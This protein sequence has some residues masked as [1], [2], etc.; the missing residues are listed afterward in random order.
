[1]MVGKAQNPSGTDRRGGHPI[2]RRV[3]SLLVA[4]L[5]LL[6]PTLSVPAA[7]GQFAS[8]RAYADPGGY[9]LEPA[10][11]DDP[12]NVFIQLYRQRHTYLR[13]SGMER[14]G[15][16]RNV[17]VVP[18]TITVDGEKVT[19]YVTTAN[20]GGPYGSSPTRVLVDIYRVDPKT[21]EPYLV[22]RNGNRL[23]E[24]VPNSTKTRP[25]DWKTSYTPSDT[26]DLTSDPV[27]KGRIR[28]TVHTEWVLDSYVGK[29][30]KATDG[31]T[32]GLSERIPCNSGGNACRTNLEQGKILPKMR[33]FRYLTSRTNLSRPK[34][35]ELKKS[36]D[37]EVKAGA[38]TK[39]QAQA[40][41][42]SQDAA[43]YVEGAHQRWSTVGQPTEA[44]TLTPATRARN[45]FTLP[46]DS[47]SGGTLT[48][49]LSNEPGSDPGGIDFSSLQLRYLSED[50]TGQLHYAFSAASTTGADHRITEGQLAAA[51]MSDA[52]FVWLS[53]PPSTFWVN[54]NPR[55][56]DRIIDPK[57]ATTDVGR[58]LLTADLR[59]K[60]LAA[61]LTNPNT[62]T[63]KQFWGTPSPSSAQECAITRQWIVPK[64]AVVYE[65]DGGLYIVD[66]PLEV[67]SEGE[68]FDGTKGDPTCP[69]PSRRMESVFDKVILPKV[70]DAVNHSPDF[71]E[72]RRVY[73]ARV[74]AEWYRQRHTGSLT[75]MIDNGDVSRWQAI[76]GWSSRSVFDEY[77]KS[78]TQG[79]YHVQKQLD[80]GNIRYTFT[81]TD[82]GVDFGSVPFSKLTQAAF[83]AQHPDQAAAVRQSFRKAASDQHGTVWLGDTG[84]VAAPA[85]V[86]GD[87]QAIPADTDASSTDATPWFSL[88]GWLG[89]TLG[90]LALLVVVIG[91]MTAAARRRRQAAA[92]AH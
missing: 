5:A 50:K 42:E 88:R 11:E 79:E 44:P 35:A 77:V 18:T 1:M 10:G 52:F 55:E 84:S 34:R 49:A 65:Q 19:V 16:E 51:Q 78:Y 13:P 15:P 62:S 73:L 57:L 59:M 76:Q 70:E 31:A 83:Q 67:K 75:S 72:L 25:V 86:H 48:N 38:K 54:L 87:P 41:L 66:A 40:E 28:Q 3:A 21:G 85:V 4:L 68:L 39:D 24:P 60:K 89:W 74:A 90:A 12:L 47:P 63:G 8:A 14:V 45:A 20:G 53:L 80:S 30:L 27:L 22:D 69:T 23:M 6:L 71:A 82:G 46:G 32:E 2:G 26:Y 36:L 92:Q 43:S 56:P 61:Q 9:Q 7:T 58:I 17:A 33:S 29:V 91:V 64:P 81:Y 37:Q